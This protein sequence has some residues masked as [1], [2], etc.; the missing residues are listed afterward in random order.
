MAGPGIEPG[1]PASL[2]RCSTTELSRPISMVHLART[3]TLFDIVMQL[4][5]ENHVE[6]GTEKEIS[7]GVA[8]PFCS[9]PEPKAEMSFFWSKFVVFHVSVVIN[10]SHFHLLLQMTGLISINLGIKHFWVKMIQVQMKGHTLFQGEIITKKRKYIDE[11][12]K[13]SPEQLIKFLPSFPRSILGW[14]G[15]KFVQWRAPPYFQGE[16]HVIT[17]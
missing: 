3:T 2:F 1:T 6:I 17:K 5:K 7:V 15:F 10:F 12:Q 9:P 4:W 14:R 13:S 16:T 8:L 11:I